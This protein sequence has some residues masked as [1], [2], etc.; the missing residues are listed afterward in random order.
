MNRHHRSAVLV[1]TVLVLVGAGCGADTGG[2]VG[3]TS[4]QPGAAPS[5]AAPVDDVPGL[6]LG[7]DSAV[8]LGG[9]WVVS[10]C[11]SGPPLFCARRGGQT[12]ATIELQSLPAANY[13]SMRAVLDAGRPPMDALR[14]EAAEFISTFEE[15]RPKGCG[16]TYDVEP[17]GPE[18]ATVAGTPGIIY[19]FDGR[20]GGRHVERAVQFLTLAGATAHLIAVNAIDEETCMDDGELAEFTTAELTELEPKLRKVIAASTLP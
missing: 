10:P 8:D 15:D 20:Q 13:A 3:G 5:T 1:A 9:G 4:P 11:E 18:P 2:V 6:D 12:Q 14:A 7:G 19:G 16:A 17:F